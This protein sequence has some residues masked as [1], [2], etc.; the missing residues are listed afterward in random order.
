MEK[1]F[2]DDG[3]AIDR[4]KTG[5]AKAFKVL[6]DRYYSMMCRFAYGI[7]RDASLSEQVADDVF[8]WIWQHRATLVISGSLRQYLMRAVRN[9]CINEMKAAAQRAERPLSG[10]SAEER[11]DF[12]MSLFSD[13]EHPL[14]MLI[15]QEL[16][17]HIHRCI[18][19]LP[20]ECR[21]VFIM[22]RI[23]Q[24]TYQEIAAALGISVNT[25]KYHIKNALAFLHGKL[26]R[27]MEVAIVML[28]LRS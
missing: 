18:N 5:D 24:K 20:A 19:L 9:R 6:F 7:L 25:V 11:A 15:G 26:G 21:R 1:L 23:E 8:F 22:S 2:L 12:I 14:G 3:H 13:G 17:Q 16:E 4:I 27:Y 28:F 10:V